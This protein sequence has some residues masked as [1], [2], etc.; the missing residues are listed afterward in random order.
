MKKLLSIILLSI[1]LASCGKDEEA[2]K[3]DQLPAVTFDKVVFYGIFA[4][5]ANQGTGCDVTITA[6]NKDNP[7]VSL[8]MVRETGVESN[9]IDIDKSG[10]YTIYDVNSPYPT[11]GRKYTFVVKLKDKSEIKSQAYDQSN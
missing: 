6:N 2:K 1:T 11:M 10:K 4:G 9:Y 3:E 7:P 8:S 5:G